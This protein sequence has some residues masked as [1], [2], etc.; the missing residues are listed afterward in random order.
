MQMSDILWSLPYSLM[1]TW[2]QAYAAYILIDYNG[3]KVDM[4]YSSQYRSE[5]NNHIQ[6]W[7]YATDL[8]D[9]TPVTS[10]C[11]KG[12]EFIDL[13]IMTCDSCGLSSRDTDVDGCLHTMM[14]TINYCIIFYMSHL[15][16]TPLYKP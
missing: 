16:F 5:A 8:G 4:L 3:K 15:F 1:K 10:F 9:R 14:K 13:E 2:G 7:S 12:G 11:T 6:F